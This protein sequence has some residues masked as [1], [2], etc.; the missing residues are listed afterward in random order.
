M[1]KRDK[2]PGL[3][4]YN[5][6]TFGGA[7]NSLLYLLRAIDK[8]RFTPVLVTTQPEE[9]LRQNFAFIEWQRVEIKLPW[10]HNRIYK[11]I[12]S[13]ELFSSGL[14]LKCVK[15]IRF[16]YW[17]LFVTLPEAVRIG[18]VGNTKFVLFT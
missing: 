8:T 12:T 5:T 14:G 10:V 9:F 16:L 2:I 7:I 17:L 3:F 6:Y 4:L 1:Q 15:R 11:K 13:H 18:S